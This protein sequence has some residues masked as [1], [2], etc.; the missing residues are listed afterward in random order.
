MPPRFVPFALALAGLLPCAGHAADAA[1]R[2]SRPEPPP[3]E[4]ARLSR[5]P[6]VISTDIGDDIDDAFA[7][8]LALR[9]PSLNVTGLIASWGDAPLRARML[10]RLLQAAGRP[11][12]P[13]AIGRSTTSTVAFSQSRWAARGPAPVS[14]ADGAD[15][16]L[17]QARRDPGRTTLL[18]LGPLTDAARAFDKDP[19]AFR[20]LKQIVLMG[21]AVREGYGRSDDRAPTPPVPEY[22]IA[23]DIAAARKVFSA[24]VPLRV[25]PLDAT[26][27]RLQEDERVS[28][29]AHG[30]ALT[31]ALGQL[32]WQWRDADQPWAS[33]TPTLFD[34]VPV[35][36]LVDPSICPTVP[37]RLEVDEA[38]MTREAAGTPNAHVCL[39][40]D[41]PAITR[42]LMR[43]LPSP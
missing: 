27:L 20:K 40:A 2:P 11:G 14:P 9:S 41:K 15:V 10:E 35:A 29:F 26:K 6:L 31:D 21:G 13:V 7:L 1:T 34:V 22:N 18:V 17:D 3:A 24:G 4:Q 19:A 12:I 43:A 5:P 28:L 23:A 38:G 16:I 30:D 8:A 25:F 37:L 42:M 39:R 33:A 36:A 32:Y